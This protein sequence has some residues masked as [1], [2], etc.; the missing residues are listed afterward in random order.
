MIESWLELA[1]LSQNWLR[2]LKN[3][4]KSMETTR[5]L[6]SNKVVEFVKIS[7]T[8]TVLMRLGKIFDWSI[9]K[10]KLDALNFSLK[11]IQL[12]WHRCHPI[13]PPGCTTIKSNKLFWYTGLFH[14]VNVPRSKRSFSDNTLVDQLWTNMK[15]NWEINALK[16]GRNGALFCYMWWSIHLLSV[17]ATVLGSRE[18]HKR[19][20]VNFVRFGRLQTD[21]VSISGIDSLANLV[22]DQ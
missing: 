12:T 22:T 13:T 20:D 7:P 5:L 15:L 11:V 19:M 16:I 17:I 8:C 1:L 14:F 10:A 3:T 4:C 6:R 18:H 2:Y 9:W 21:I